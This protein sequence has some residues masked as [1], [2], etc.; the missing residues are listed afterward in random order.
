VT[1]K[2]ERDAELRGSLAGALVAFQADMPTVHKGKTANVGTYSYKYADLADIVQTA[3]PVLHA[4]GLSFSAAPRRT[5]QG[6]YELVGMLRHV[7]GESDEGSLPLNGRSAQEIGS[8][9]TYARRYL[10]GCLTGIVTDDDEDGQIANRTTSPTRGEPSPEELL[11]RAK[12][13]VKEA[14][15][16]IHGSWDPEGMRNHY[17]QQTALPLDDATAA[18]LQNYARSLLT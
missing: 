6:T 10:L 18:D 11:N 17:E 12:Q 1:T 13:A 8:A 5:E 7:S 3:T 14:W 15:E 16:S 9:I 4:H 2:E